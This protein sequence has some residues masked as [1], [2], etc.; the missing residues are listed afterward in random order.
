[1]GAPAQDAA[2]YDDD[3]RER[4]NAFRVALCPMGSQPYS[5]RPDTP[6]RRFTGNETEYLG[7]SFTSS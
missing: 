3:Q 6:F 2:K 1:M 5:N 7:G 4:E